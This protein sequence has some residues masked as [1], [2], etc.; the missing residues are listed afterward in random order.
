MRWCRIVDSTVS[1]RKI[2]QVVMVLVTLFVENPDQSEGSD[3]AGARPSFAVER[4]ED[5]DVDFL[6]LQA[7]K[8]DRDLI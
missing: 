5:M 7:V 6:S 1:Y 8:S 4:G 3:R 2:R